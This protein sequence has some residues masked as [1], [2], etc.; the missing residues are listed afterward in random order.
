[1]TAN[2]VILALGLSLQAISQI[3]PDAGGT[4]SRLPTDRVLGD[5]TRIQWV[6]EVKLSPNG[7]RMIFARVKPGSTNVYGERAD[8]YSMGLTRGRWSAPAI[9]DSGLPTDLQPQWLPDG[10]RISYLSA[11]SG[12]REVWIADVLTRRSFRSRIAD[13]PGMAVS[14]PNTP[15]RRRETG[16]LRTRFR[17]R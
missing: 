8:L 12:R 7:G 1:M 3:A 9:V 2:L 13:V 11:R 5:L 10:R 16:C 17:R 4:P 6:N 14:S 15:S